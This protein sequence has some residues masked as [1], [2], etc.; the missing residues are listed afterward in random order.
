MK[1]KS[2]KT[3]KELNNTEGPILVIGGG[4]YIGT[5]VVEK[6]LEDGYKVRIL[7]RFVFGKKVVS[8]LLGDVSDL[9]A[10]SRALQGAKAVVHLAGLVGDPAC[11]VDENM[12]LHINIA[13]TRV[14]KE[15]SKAF[16]VPHFIFASSCSVYGA[17]DEIM[18][19]GSSLNPV[20]LYAKTKIDS[21]QEILND[22][23]PDFN[24]TILRFATVFGH[25]RRPRFDLVANL[26]TAQAYND[27]RITVTG[28][29]Q[30]RP[31]IHAA[32]IARAIVS[33]ISSP[34]EKVR[35]QIF[36][37]GDEQLNTTIDGLAE[38]VARVVRKGKNGKKVEIQIRDDVTDRRNYRVSFD[39][40]LNSLDFRAK[41]S[42]EDGVKEI[43][44]KFRTGIYKNHYQHRI[45]INVEMTKLLQ[46]EFYSP[47]YRENKVSILHDSN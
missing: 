28:R 32:D 33:V 31:F 5:H 12:T 11:A 8:D 16:K 19:E 40:I 36:N 17:S 45:Y 43:H 14:V 7:D 37:V 6:L 42:L 2:N 41:N 1:S 25:S 20:S 21:E 34:V 26:F 38:L 27:G 44:E 23:T 10:L 24:P 13:S 47:E 29:G 30:W 18:H 22:K 3:V 15:M 4:G 9:V 35:R 39:K 46:E